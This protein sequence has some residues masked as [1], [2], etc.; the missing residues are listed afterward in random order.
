MPKKNVIKK[1]ALAPTALIAG[2]AGFIGS[3][4]C[5]ALLSR[6]AR[7]IVLDNFN[8]GKDIH[9]NHLLQNPNFALYNVDINSGLPP[10]IESVDYIFHM[11]GLEEYLFSKELVNLTALLTN[12]VGTKNLL[13]LAQRSNAKFLLASSIDVYEGRMSQL[14]LE[15]YFGS[16]KID[17]NKYML[18]EA[19]RYAEALVWEYYKKNDTDLRIVRLPEIYGPRM[20]LSSSGS[21]GTFMR[22]LIEHR[23][24]T[25]TGEG[26]NKE[27]YLYIS[28]A[29][30]GILKAL[31]NEN[32]KGTIY[33]LV[34]HQPTSVLQLAYL[35]KNVADREV[36]I[37]FKNDEGQSSYKP[38]P[39]IPD[40][41]NLTQLGWDP[42]VELKEGLVKSLEYFGYKSN[43]HSFKPAELIENKAGVES[44]VTS[45]I[46]PAEELFSLQD[47]KSM[48]PIVQA[49]SAV[50]QPPQPVTASP[51][52]VSTVPTFGNNA[53]IANFKTAQPKIK[54]SRPSVFAAFPFLNKF[55]SVA[56]LSFLGVFISALL[57]F[58]VLPIAQT[59]FYVRASSTALNSLATSVGQL[60][61][62]G[63]RV[64]ARASYKNLVKAK[65]SFENLKWVF[66]VTNKK[67]Q[68]ES[69]DKLISS[70]AHFSKS[71]YTLAEA[72][73]PFENLWEVVRPD[74]TTELDPTSFENVKTQVE[75]SKNSFQ[76]AVADFKNVNTAVLPAMVQEKAVEYSK[77][78]EIVSKGLDMAVPV[79]SSFPNI[80]GADQSKK[81]M[82]LFQ[83]S[84]EIRPTGGFIGS[85]GLLTFEK[86]K[87][88]DLVIDDI[89][90]PDGQIDLKGIS[91]AP[92]EQIKTFLNE[93]KLHIRNANWDPDFP[94]SANTISDLYYRVTGEKLDGI[95]AVDLYFVQNIL[96]ATGP[97]FLTAYNEEI[98]AENLYERAEYHSEFNY[99]NGSDSKR[100]FLTVLGGKLMEKIF[101]LSR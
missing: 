21:L 14:E 82:I 91:V 2:G 46:A 33:S 87:I 25:V 67:D 28:D 98:N 3:H 35:V 10:E 23:N 66:V 18:T 85:Y 68:F 11:A 47:V 52:P 58:L 34:W 40:L 65:N 71:G 74:T 50:T 75:V 100:S 93:D 70:L 84:N 60:D 24:I 43:V 41:F 27:Y 36:E 62:E 20:D 4:L 64:N 48:S 80:L 92:S 55:R 12:A 5:E 26:S 22:D 90:N 54:K 76:L 30:S 42:R 79:L 6:G 96:R 45:T 59:Y 83:N 88:K 9:I 32:S 97:I 15:E 69:T 94:T 38:A 95:I 89:Y 56:F 81:Y 8:T 1:S 101:S 63:V 78:L 99:V 49:P 77:T 7:V 57:I 19:K 72:I 51:A 86:G 29:V 39:K 17:E 37:I 16:N 13:D 31:F 44:V 53:E 61:S 73:K